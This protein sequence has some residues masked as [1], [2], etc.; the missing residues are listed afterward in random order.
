MFVPDD[1]VF[2][3]PSPLGSSFNFITIVSE[4]P[5]SF[6]VVTSYSCPS[7]SPKFTMSPTPNTVASETDIVVC[8]ADSSAL[9]VVTASAE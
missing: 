3:K 5:L 9:V 6:T 7:V 8:P 2:C 1:I 4:L